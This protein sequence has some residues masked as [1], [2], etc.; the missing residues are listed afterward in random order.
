MSYIWSVLFINF[1][2]CA[3][4]GFREGYMITK[5][6][7]LVFFPLFCSISLFG[8][9]YKVKHVS[10]GMTS[11]E[12]SSFVSINSSS[13]I[14]I[15]IGTSGVYDGVH[16]LLLTLETK[17]L[18]WIGLA[19]GLN[20]PKR[21]FFTFPIDIVLSNGKVI[22]GKPRQL[23]SIAFYNLTGGN[24]YVSMGGTPFVTFDIILLS[25]CMEVNGSTE[26]EKDKNFWNLLRNYDIKQIRVRSDDKIILTEEFSEIKTSEIIKQ[27]TDFFIKENSSPSHLSSSTSST[28]STPSTSSTLSSKEDNIKRVVNFV[29]FLIDKP[30][31]C[32][33]D[34]DIKKSQFKQSI[35][36]KNYFK[37]LENDWDELDKHNE[38]VDGRGYEPISGYYLMTPQELRVNDIHISP[39]VTF[40]GEKLIAYDYSIYLSERYDMNDANMV[41]SSIA[42]NLGLKKTG[43]FKTYK[44]GYILRGSCLYGKYKDSKIFISEPDKNSDYIIN[45]Y[46]IKDKRQSLIQ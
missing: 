36:E 7:F 32:L 28:S 44:L 14:K 12:D 19:E 16:S 31:G 41:M 11:I 5:K 6:L 25:I 38:Y 35:I 45:I 22:K 33:D 26:K 40:A 29:R 30:W 27:K 13:N 34:K 1:K 46:I 9:N 2:S 21:P 39:T 37:T 3:R 10:S 43:K 24:L 15:R 20:I 23:N 42:Q 4:H 8:G 17:S 18:N